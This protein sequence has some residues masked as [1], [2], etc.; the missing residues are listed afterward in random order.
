MSLNYSVSFYRRNN[1]VQARINGGQTKL[2]KRITTKVKIPSGV[3][4]NENAGRLLGDT[5]VVK[6]LN[7]QL[8]RFKNEV[9]DCL[10]NAHGTFEDAI[11]S[12]DWERVQKFTKGGLEAC[13]SFDM[14]I[15]NYCQRASQGQVYMPGTHTR[16]TEVGLQDLANLHRFIDVLSDDYGPWY[17]SDYD[18]SQAITSFERQ[19][20][21]DGLMRVY[22]NVFQFMDQ[23]GISHDLIK[24]W[25]S[26]LQDVLVAEAEHKNIILPRWWY[27]FEELYSNSAEFADW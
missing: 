23:V 22:Q 12:I 13:D 24:S 2:N 11:K 20:K 3:K 5:T 25:I 17:L 6:D 19:V 10:V 18:C 1:V 4:W 7:E 21:W 16:Y 15:L 14:A 26:F 27:L 9:V 8:D